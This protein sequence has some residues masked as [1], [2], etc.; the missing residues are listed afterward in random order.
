MVKSFAF[1][2]H[3]SKEK[4]FV[5]SL[6]LDLGKE[7][8]FLDK[9]DLDAG[10]L[11]PEEI[12][13]GIFDAKWFVIIA[14]KKAMESRWVKYEI[15]LAIVRWIEEQDFKIIVAKIEECDIP[16]HLKPFV[17]VNEPNNP[18]KA[19]KDLVKLILTEGKGII[20]NEEWNVSVVNRYEELA[21]IEELYIQKIRL[22]ILWGMY[23][24]GKTTLVDHASDK[25][26]RKRTSRFTIT[27][28]HDDYRLAL[29][30][31]ARA[32][33]PFPSADAS[34]EQLVDVCV[35]AAKELEKQGKI[36]FFDEVDLALNE[37]SKIK[38]YLSDIVKQI[39]DSE[40]NFPIFMTSTRFVNISDDLLPKTH[41]MK[42][43][44]LK[45]DH[46]LSI[47]ERW[48]KLADPEFPSPDR[49]LLKLA[50]KELHGYPL[51]TR[52]ASYVIVKYSI[53]EVMRDLK[54]F[55]NIRIDAAKQL[56]GRS[57]ERLN[58]NHIDILTCLTLADNGLTQFDLSK[59][60]SK[61][62]DE[63]RSGI[64]E[65]TSYQFISVNKNRLE[66]LSL[67]KDY[68]WRIVVSNHTLHK[69]SE[70]I[71]RHA[72]SQLSAVDH[73]SEDFIHYCAMAY[74]LFLLADK[75][76]DANS[77]S[78][79]FKGELREAVIRLFHSKEWNLSLKYSNLILKANPRDKQILYY[80]IRCLTKLEHFREAEESLIKLAEI[81]YPGYLLDHAEG[82][83]FKQKGEIEEAAKI[84]KKGLEKRD[85]YL[86]LLREYGE[87]L[88]RLG[89]L[90][91]AYD[92][93]SY[94]YSIQPRDKYI[95]PRYVAVL[96]KMGRIVDALDIMNDLVIT[97]PEEASFHHTLS[98]L[99]SHLGND[100]YAYDHAKLA[101]S[102]D[103]Q[104]HEAVMHF[105]S[106]EIKRNHI[107]EAKQLLQT[108]PEHLSLKQRIIR[109]TIHAEIFL[110]EGELES[111]KKLLAPYHKVEDSYCISVLIRI[112]IQE[113]QHLISNGQI[114]A[115][116]IK[117]VKN[118][119]YVE[120]QLQ[121]FSNDYTFLQLQSQLTQIYDRI[122][123]KT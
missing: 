42:I 114:R 28:G 35:A 98:M 47:L 99:Y 89:D 71:A 108:L 90:D 95:V 75:Y 93:L 84:F 60:L 103:R 107:S 116:E 106:L 117:T 43:K 82:L 57:R 86:P 73:D 87:M 120:E 13:R 1:L 102:L 10:D 38:D 92:Q 113:I 78:I 74:R 49:E 54:H 97:F 18:I 19:K 16:P 9:W 2:S 91:G 17:F 67:M 77:L 33:I 41:L 115:A 30:M 39:L 122:K 32:K 56:I 29:E 51:A 96:E 111:A 23:G 44:A 62:I 104:Q 118:M 53:E 46:I 27:R 58:Q 61:D 100:N 65:L 7:N 119:E 63:I 4:E 72:Q 24:I 94:A 121:K 81:G 76:D 68:F 12:A 20:S 70:K 34:K 3:S 88:E 45:D 14:S 8:V 11:L 101:V 25:I 5:E 6:A 22:I 52:I 110:K 48:I 50:S 123:P 15:N 55:T 105:A 109:D 21:T 69:L 36:I 59:I 83:L 66:V 112:E 80:K 26:F 37:E 40:I 79:Y 85:D 31:A 64:D